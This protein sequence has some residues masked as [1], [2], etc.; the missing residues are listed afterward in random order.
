MCAHVDVVC[1]LWY[2]EEPVDWGKIS[3]RVELIFVRELIAVNSVDLFFHRAL[4][5]YSE[6]TTTTTTREQT[7][8]KVRAAAM[9]RCAAAVIDF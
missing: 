4:T 9:S 7:S 6:G 2:V 1:G 5:R 3:L 8:M